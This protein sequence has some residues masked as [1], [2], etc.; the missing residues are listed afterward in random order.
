MLLNLVTEK[1]FGYSREELLGQPVE[2]L[3]P[4]ASRATT[5]RIVPATGIIRSL[6]RA[7]V[8]LHVAA[9]TVPLSRSKSVSAQ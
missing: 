7:G 6:D 5:Y 2:I 3:I 1:V 4:D 8:A 9:K